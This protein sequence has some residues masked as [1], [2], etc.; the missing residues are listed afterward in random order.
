MIRSTAIA[1]GVST[2]LLLAGADSATRRLFPA[3]HAQAAAPGG[4][5]TPADYDGDGRTDAT[6]FRPSNGTWYTL[7][8]GGATSTVA[9]GLATDVPVLGDYDGDGRSDRAVFRP[10]DATWQIGRAHV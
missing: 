8:S 7:Q 9:W 4:R 6:I 3:V 2:I 10:S 1:F 5:I